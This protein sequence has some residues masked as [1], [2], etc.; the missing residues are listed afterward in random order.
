LNHALF[1]DA[2]PASTIKPIMALAFMADNP[3]YQTGEP[4]K[5]LW[6]DLKTSNSANFLDRLFCGDAQSRHPWQWQDCQRPMRTQQMPNALGWNLYCDDEVSADCGK[7]DVL[8]GR[9][10]GRRW[11]KEGEPMG[12]SLLYGRVMT[13]IKSPDH[14]STVAMDDWASEGSGAIPLNGYS[15]I[16]NFSFR[17]SVIKSCSQ[18]NFC[19]E[20]RGQKRWRRCKG[21]GRLVNEGW[22]QGEARVTP[23]GVA[24]MMARLAAAANGYTSQAYP[25]LVERLT[26]TQGHQLEVMVERHTGEEPVILDPALARLVLKGMGSHQVGGTAHAACKNVFNTV[27][28]DK[29]DWL[30]G[31]TGTP[32]FRFDQV[33]LANIR[34]YCYQATDNPRTECNLLPYK[35]Y[36]A[37]FKTQHELGVGHDKA[38]AVLSERN[39]RKRTGLVQAPGDHEVNLSAELALRIIKSLRTPSNIGS[40]GGRQGTAP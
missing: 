6:H 22:G 1:I 5:A 14:T 8:F 13:E 36:V 32:P 21:V 15:L 23:V 37:A 24:G 39:W 30:A 4:L 10:S 29:M 3:A 16:H 35:W 11:V 38:I 7:L 9:P 31:K 18:G 20:C 19:P 34:Q 33:P 17:D 40:N 12:L 26:D 28:C 2:M 27:E 25:H